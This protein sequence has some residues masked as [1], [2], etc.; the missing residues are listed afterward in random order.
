MNAHAMIAKPKA[1][2]ETLEEV[3]NELSELKHLLHYL[4]AGLESD[5]DIKRGKIAPD[6]HTVAFN[7]QIDNTDAT[8]WLCGTCWSRTADLKEK[9]LSLLNSMEEAEGANG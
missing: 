3:C 7:F 1:S 6:G 2:V 8:L 9:A 5:F 4:M